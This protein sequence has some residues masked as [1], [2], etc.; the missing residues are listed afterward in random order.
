MLAAR[1]YDGRTARQ[2]AV[3]LAVSDGRVTVSGEQ[4]AR[5]EAL[6]DVEFSESY[7]GMPRTLGFRDGTYC[8]IDESPELAAMLEAAGVQRSWVE[9]L[10]ASWAVAASAVVATMAII[11][12]GYLWGL[13]VAA[14]F[15]ARAMP[16]AVARLLSQQSIR[17]LDEVWLVPSTLAADR[18]HQLSEG[19]ARLQTKAADAT[20]APVLLFRSA[21]KIGANAFA[22]P[23]GTI[24]LF[25]ELV[26]LADDDAQI[27]GV[28]GHELGHVE[29]RHGLRL[30]IRSS[31]LAAFSAWWFGDASSLLAAAPVALAQAR[32]SREFETEA[33]D[34]AAR[35]LRNAGLSPAKLAEML[36][37]L[38]AAHG[39]KVE[40]REAQ[41]EPDW[42]DYLE[43]HPAPTERV[44]RLREAG[45]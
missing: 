38:G 31:L 11:V 24:V 1:Y 10:Q 28:L 42:L 14:D 12:A 29:H 21:P 32:Y 44:R 25:D 39:L 19:F 7:A 3:M 45:D 13:P 43:S 37:K 36:E 16:P 9:T 41:G 4:V 33:D 17:L 20:P 34:H 5:N 26:A 18:Q 40:A 2:H 6:S 23:D 22:L 15:A 35:L 30:L 8:E 27:L